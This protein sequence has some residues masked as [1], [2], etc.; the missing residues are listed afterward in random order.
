[1]KMFRYVLLMAFA[2][3]MLAVPSSAM[4]HC[5]VPCGIYDDHAR[6]VGMLEDV[7]TIKKAITVMNELVAKDDI[8]SRQQFVRWVNT[9]EMHA[10]KIISTISDYFLTQRVKASQEDYVQRLKDHHAVIVGA[11]KAKQ[12]A[13]MEVADSLEAAV[14][15]LLNYYHEH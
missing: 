8:Q 6:V 9:K 1:M 12:Q 5:Q 2:A 11:M 10:Q 4:A 7:A 15:V 13:S 14:K 3:L